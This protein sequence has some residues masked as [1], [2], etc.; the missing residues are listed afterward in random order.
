MM[1]DKPAA[2]EPT[3]T[4]EKGAEIPVPKRGDVFQALKKIAKA[5]KDTDEES[6]E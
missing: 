1:P 2:D 5:E 4:T 6:D 3:Q